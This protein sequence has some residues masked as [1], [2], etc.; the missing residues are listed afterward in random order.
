MP[1]IRFDSQAEVIKK[2]NRFLEVSIEHLISK[3][4]TKMVRDKIDQLL[5]EYNENKW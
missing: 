5:D 2:Q 3:K 4:H 1:Q